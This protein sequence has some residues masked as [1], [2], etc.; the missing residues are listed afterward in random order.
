MPQ[1]PKKKVIEY[2]FSDIVETSSPEN[3]AI[4]YDFSDIVEGED[5]KK[6]D[7][8]SVSPTQD[9][10]SVSTEPEIG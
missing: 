10:V 5:V 4:E 9:G 2:D 6:K 7:T 3:E 8:T 1:D